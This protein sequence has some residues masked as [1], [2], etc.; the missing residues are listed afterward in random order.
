MRTALQILQSAHFTSF[1]FPLPRPLPFIDCRSQLIFVDD[2]SLLI[3]LQL[4]NFQQMEIGCELGDYN[5]IT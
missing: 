5:L 2:L 1:R 4:C 3:N